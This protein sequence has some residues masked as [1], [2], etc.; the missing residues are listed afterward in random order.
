MKI[1]IVED[2]VPLLRLMTRVVEKAGHQTYI[3]SDGR[4]ALEVF[5]ANRAEIEAAILD[6]NIPPDGVAEILDRILLI[7][8]DLAV[9]V[10]SGGIPSREVN[11]LLAH[12]GGEFLAKPFVP[13]ALMSAL[14]TS[15]AGV[16]ARAG[17]AN[18]VEEDS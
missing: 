9:V 8:P 2:E 18:D 17:E 3:A 16:R 7:R 14:E 12:C 6:I 4:E 11:E 10:T 15:L 5:R 1:L 13:K